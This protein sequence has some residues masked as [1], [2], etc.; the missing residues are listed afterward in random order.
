LRTWQKKI[1]G[2]ICISEFVKNQLIGAGIPESKLFRK[3]NFILE[4]PAFND[5]PADD[6]LYVGRLSPEKGIGL[7]LEAFASPELAGRSL[8]VIGNGPMRDEVEAAAARHANIRYLGTLDL[9]TT[10]RH[11]GQAFYLVFPSRW[12]EP[13]GRTIVE[14]FACGTPVIASDAGAAPELITHRH[15][16]LLFTRD[17]IPSLIAKIKE[18]C[19]DQ[20][21]AQKR[22]NAR[23]TYL[24]R[25]T[26]EINYTQLMDIYAAV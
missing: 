11:M 1:D 23:E 6:F 9:Q 8:T 16:G 3:Y 22:R 12:H 21:Y 15:N 13:F 14:A 24:E 25:F 18:A 4:D 2:F 7:L 5:R 10:Y 20:D 19:D 17:N 26:M